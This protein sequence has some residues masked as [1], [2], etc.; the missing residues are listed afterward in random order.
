MLELRNIKK[1]YPMGNTVVHALKG[2]SIQFRRS[3]FVSILGPSGCGKTTLLNIIGGLDQ[4]TDGDL[5]INGRS[6]KSFQDRD[7]DSYRNHS[8]G[9]VF[10]SYNLIP[11]QTVLR[12]VELALT[13]SG[14]SRS[15]RRDRAVEALEKV[16]LGNQL[17]K[18][19]SEMSGGQ[20]QRVAIARAIV[21]NPD[22]IL[23]DEPTGALDTETSVQVMELLK[24]ISKDRLIVMV[25]HNP[26]LAEKYSSR[27]I[28]VLDGN[29]IS[30]SNPLTPAE[31]EQE[32]AVDNAELEANKGKKIRKPSMSF[33]TS[34]GLSLKNLFTKK[35]RTTLTAFAGSIGIIGIAL[36]L[37][38]SR[39]MTD[40][41]DVTQENALSSY[42]LSIQATNIDLTSLIQTFMNL[43]TETGDH[44][45]DAV[46]ER[47][48]VQELVS[49][50][51]N[52]DVAQN[53]LKSFKTYLEG[54]LADPE[55]ALSGALSGIQYSYNISPQIYTK[56]ADGEI[57]HSDTTEMMQQLLI[58]MM[59]TGAADASWMTGS[60]GTTSG[61]TSATDMTSMSSMM[62]GGMMTLWQELLPGKDGAAVNDLL[63][64]QYDLI[65]GSWPSSYDQVVL[66][67]DENN[68]LDD[69][70][71]YALGLISQDEMMDIADGGDDTARKTQWSY[72][73]ICNSDFRLILPSSCYS[74]DENTGLYTDLRDTDAGLKYLYDN[75]LKLH[76]TG[77]IRQNP[78][79]ETTMISGKICYT[80]GLIDYIV[81]QANQS[82]AVQAQKANPDKDVL[83]GLPFASR[84]D[85]L[86]K[87]EKEKE[88][89]AY[90]DGLDQAGKAQVY[91]QIMSLPDEDMITQQVDQM[92]ADMSRD[93]MVSTLSQVLTQQMSVSQDQ[94]DSYLADMSEED[95]KSTFSQMLTAQMKTQYAQQVTQ[96]LAMLP[97]SQKV[98]ALELAM[99]GYTPDQW[100]EYYD[101]IMEFSDATYED[102][103][104]TLGCV[105]LDSPSAIN[106]YSASFDSKD[107]V[108]A[109]IADYNATVDELHQIS[110]TDYVGLMMSAVT[111]IINAITYVL[112]AF[113]A[114]S[115]IV[116]SIMIG[117]ITLISVQERTR[118]IGI[119]RAIG[120]SKRDVS[121]MFNAETVIIG[122]AS[123]LLGVLV[124]YLLCIPI[125]MVMHAVTKIQSLNAV[126]PVPAA[127]I[128]IAISVF[129]TLISGLI[130]SRSA[131][132]KDPV[133]ALRSE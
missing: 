101:K 17:Y 59:G 52:L 75:A 56:N 30:D 114:I 12:N 109:V 11:H 91:V 119:L 118:E 37:S 71:L 70:T 120:A 123:G 121:V 81:D 43:N 127:I 69:M 98:S 65:Y 38:V 63:I 36:I 47:P 45:K 7:W 77:I 74:Y 105:D 111:S 42:P 116:S 106:L 129:L 83:T 97:D 48:A 94:I 4:Y 14:V 112:I 110:Y 29:L 57:I 107:A 9:F 67:V 46:Y 72:E 26:P 73:E 49:A 100:A 60:S 131:A 13:L 85:S 89:R 25:T 79:V 93:D 39:G 24:E 64:R 31:V 15:Q 108:E 78:D 103:L 126:L 33:A 32:R 23:A 6:T 104:T 58:S 35:G 88:M 82:E 125:N 44:D 128:L 113:V 54:Q 90:I 3:E 18:R 19:P 41:I 10:Q 92:L 86:T 102:N 99:D 61:S 40:Y 96:Q 5:I 28:R 130:P 76:V 2:V 8:V 117:V 66:V 124:T 132:K 27:I 21:N 50:I 122:F 20:M 133:V 53:D 84:A 22:I 80:S 55:S 1:D 115:L 95:L 62:G 87:A 68:E 51:N 34:F 16:G